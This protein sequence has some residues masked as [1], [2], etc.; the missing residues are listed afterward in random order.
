MSAIDA[1]ISW[2]DGYDPDYQQRLQ[3]FCASQGI[4]K[5]IAVEPTRIQQCDEIYYCLHALQRFAPWIRTIYILT[6]QQVPPAIG[7]L[8]FRHKIKI[9]D[10]NEL[11]RALNITT[12]IFNSISA[13]WLIWR[14]PGLSK[15][16]LYLNDDFF[17]I[18]AVKPED[19]FRGQCSVFYGEWK[20]QA[21]NKFA[22]RFKK[23]WFNT[24]TRPKTDPHR[25][26][27]EKSAQL[28]GWDKQFYLLPHAPFPLNKTTFNTYVMDHQDVVI[29]NS[30]YPFRHPE[31]ISSIPL[32]AHLDM[33]KGR[34]IYGSPRRAVMVNGAC[35]SLKKIQ[36]RLQRAQ[37]KSQV[38]FVCMQ[39]I[40][41]A[42]EKTKRYMIDWLHDSLGFVN[43]SHP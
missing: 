29:K 33:K 28:A 11:L 24:I 16:F 34:A 8:S 38:A 4:E 13:E 18:R 30:S 23:F 25:A 41:Q 20:V 31:Q 10:Q 40:D 26:W 36:S 12:P 1:V 32:M 35:H 9:I 2:V 15:H 3:A 14:I 37:K 27:Q 6:D 22:F 21:A 43:E 42:P 5:D 19:F 7:T 17:L 39:S